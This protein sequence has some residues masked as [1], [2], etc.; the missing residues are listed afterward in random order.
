[1]RALSKRYGINQKTVAKWKKRTSIADL[2]TGPKEPKSTVLSTEDEAIIIA[3]RRHTLLPLDDC[4]YSL[5][6]TIPHLTR[7]SLHRCLQRHG[8]SRL[9]DIDGDKPAKK[10]FKAYPIGYFHIDIAQVQTAEGKL[11]LFVA[12]DRTSKFAFAHLEESANIHTAAAFL[13]ALVKAV[14][15]KIHT[16]LTDNGIQFCD[17]PSRRNGPTARL[18]MHMFDRTCRTHGIEHRLTKPNHPWTNGQVERMNRTIK[19]ATVKRYHYDS[20]D[21]LTRHLTDFLAAYNFGRR[22]KTL[23]GLTPYEFICRQW[24]SEPKNFSLNPIH[25]FPGL[26]T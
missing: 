1:M 21:Q 9:I 14:P 4:L 15:Y 6:A 11:Q 19:E 18:R 7:S 3:F 13:K 23:K 16:V 25:Q 20:H 12:I 22:L 8:I 17:L 24:T 2:P 5:Q 26:N 10:K